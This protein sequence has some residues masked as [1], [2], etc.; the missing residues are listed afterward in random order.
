M[1][2]S[3]EFR[4]IVKNAEAA[5]L[6]RDTFFPFRVFIPEQRMVAPPIVEQAKRTRR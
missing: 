5:I 3:R 2:R 1:E 6:G 4:G